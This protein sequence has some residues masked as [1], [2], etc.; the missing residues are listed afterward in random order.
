M[1][2]SASI[3]ASSPVCGKCVSGIFILVV[4]P[5]TVLSV[6]SGV[7]YMHPNFSVLVFNHDFRTSS[8]VIPVSF[9]Y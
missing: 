6:G 1:Y 2:P 7:A 9:L 3:S 5:S 8:G 4:L